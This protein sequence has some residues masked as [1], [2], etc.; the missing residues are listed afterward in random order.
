MYLASVRFWA[1][2]RVPP[3]CGGGERYTT[4]LVSPVLNVRCLRCWME[5]ITLLGPKEPQEDINR[6]R[7]M[8]ARHNLSSDKST[9]NCSRH[10]MEFVRTFGY[11]SIRKNTSHD[12]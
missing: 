7:E 1:P 2:L 8:K 4:E 6:N 11:S 3:H 5:R 10:F 9:T 12:D